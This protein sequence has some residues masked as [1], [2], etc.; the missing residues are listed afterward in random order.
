MYSVCKNLVY[1]KYRGF[2]SFLTHFTHL[3]EPFMHVIR[4][5]TYKYAPGT[6]RGTS[7]VSPIYKPRLSVVITC[8]VPSGVCHDNQSTC[9]F[10][11]MHLRGVSRLADLGRAGL[12]QP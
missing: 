10:N 2:S 3:Q 12:R 11:D 1:V 6:Q 9:T 8:K 5:H 7:L 4:T